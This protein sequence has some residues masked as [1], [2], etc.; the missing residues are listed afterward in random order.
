MSVTFHVGKE[1]VTMN[2]ES[3]EMETSTFTTNICTFK[4]LQ[5][6]NKI[7]DLDFN[8]YWFQ[9]EKA[10]LSNVFIQS[11]V[12]LILGSLQFPNLCQPPYCYGRFFVCLK[13]GLSRSGNGLIICYCLETLS[14]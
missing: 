5:G 4:L 1:G 13:I 3:V 8:R 14:S 10:D 9:L 7:K 11:V 6:L 2:R 12:I